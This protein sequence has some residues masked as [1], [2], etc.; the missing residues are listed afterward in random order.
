MEVR[1]MEE[2]VLEILESICNT[3]EVREDMDINLFDNGLLDSLGII[4]LILE[5]E[6]ELGIVIQPTEVERKD[7]D[8]PNRIIKYLETR[9]K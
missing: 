9:V 5:I 2:K 6:K 3:D 4:E 8:T 7:I 1:L